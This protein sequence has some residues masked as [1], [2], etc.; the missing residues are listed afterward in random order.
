MVSKYTNSLFSLG[1]LS[2]TKLLH[3]AFECR[4]HSIGGQIQ[5]R[6]TNTKRLSPFTLS[7]LHVKIDNMGT[8]LVACYNTPRTDVNRSELTTKHDLM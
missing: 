4:L 2:Q 5:V 7:A 1:G 8:V 6:L 3:P